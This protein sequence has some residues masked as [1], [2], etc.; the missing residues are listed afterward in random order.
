MSK[1]RSPGSR[2]AIL[3]KALT[4]VDGFY[5]LIEVLLDTDRGARFVPREGFGP[6]V[7]T[8]DK[9]AACLDRVSAVVEDLLGKPSL[10]E[11]RPRLVL[12]RDLRSLRFLTLRLYVVFIPLCLFFF[13]MTLD[14]SG[15]DPAVWFV[16]AVL[17]FLLLFPLIY[18]RRLRLNLEHRCHYRHVDG[19]EACIFMEELKEAPFHSYLAHEYAHHVYGTL[20][21]HGQGDRWFREGW[22][23]LIQWKVCDRLALEEANHAFLHHVLLQ[24][25]G[26]LKFALTVMGHALRLRLPGRAKRVKNIFRINSLVSFFTGNPGY[27]VK[28]LLNHALG[29]AFFA[30][31]LKRMSFHEATLQLPR[32]DAPENMSFPPAPP[33]AK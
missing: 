31:A 1:K 4:T 30:L 20:F 18:R 2:A 16:R 5:E 19:G 8:D 29:T 10:P 22:C 24:V 25:T 21:G 9:A 28:S 15:A 27:D 11:K 3:P 23:R 13:Y 12:L 26:E 6:A 32:R 14:H 7:Q 33:G 17:L